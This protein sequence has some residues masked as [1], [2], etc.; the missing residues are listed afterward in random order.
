MTARSSSISGSATTNSAVSPCYTTVLALTEEGVV[1]HF[2]AQILSSGQ[3]GD[4]FLLA[5]PEVPGYTLQAYP[6]AL[7][8]AELRVE[9][10]MQPDIRSVSRTAQQRLEQLGQVLFGG[11]VPDVLRELSGQGFR[12]LCLWPHGPLWNMPLQLLMPARAAPSPMTGP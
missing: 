10:Q 11:G 6:W 8:M 7:G 4:V 2:Q 3:D 12:H 1:T 9:L 5:D